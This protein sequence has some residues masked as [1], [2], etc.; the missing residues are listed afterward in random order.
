MQ[1]AE[2]ST[3]MKNQNLQIRTKQFAVPV[4]QL[5]ERLPNDETSK[6]LRRQLLRAG[7]SVGQITAQHAGQ[8]RSQLSSPKWEMSSKKR[9]S[10]GIGPNSCWS[11][12]KWM[13][14]P[15]HQY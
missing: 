1:S 3:P 15:R 5:W 7:T 6:I 14:D 8:N 13:R 4:I 2:C 9:T 10:L 11:Q 12:E